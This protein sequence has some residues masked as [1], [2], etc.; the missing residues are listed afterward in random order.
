MPP[1]LSRA[2]S[3][4]PNR[5]RDWAAVYYLPEALIALALVRF[6]LLIF[7]LSR[8]RSLGLPVVLRRPNMPLDPARLARAVRAGSRLVPFASCLTQAQAAQ[9]LLAR[10]GIASTVC[11]GVRAT[12]TGELAA[13]AWLLAGGRMLLGG[14]TREL[15]AFRQLAKLGPTC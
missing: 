6:G 8:V 11:L 15:A 14:G 13:H 1:L 2:L 7:G 5:S 12:A 10:H 4:P 9:I 3:R